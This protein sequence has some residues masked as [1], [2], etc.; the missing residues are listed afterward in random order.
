MKNIWIELRD[1]EESSGVVP[2]EEGEFDSL[3]APELHYRCGVKRNGEEFQLSVGF[4]VAMSLPC[5]RCLKPTGYHFQ[6]EIEALCSQ[7]ADEEEADLESGTYVLR[8]NKGKADISVPLLQEIQLN[9][10]IAHYC[11]EDCPGICPSCGSYRPCDCANGVRN[12]FGILKDLF[13]NNK[14]E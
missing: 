14:E 1:G 10:P 12:P 7:R 5:A 11:S 2:L 3:D 13:A 8:M 9:M 6:S 4:E